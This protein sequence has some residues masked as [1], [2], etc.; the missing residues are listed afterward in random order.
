[1]NAARPIVRMRAGNTAT[2]GRTLAVVAIFALVG[3]PIGAVVIWIVFAIIDPQVWRA[4]LTLSPLELLQ[5]F[6]GTVLVAY[7]LGAA[8]SA[9]AGLVVML[10]RRANGRTSLQAPVVAA[11][12]ADAVGTIF[13]VGF[14]A[15]HFSMTGYLFSFVPPSLVAAIVC[16]LIA[17][18]VELI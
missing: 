13:F 6:F 15:G 4:I 9:L 10:L 16:W 14:G 12:V 17:R 8:L 2:L 11:L 7:K 5:F 18:K 1:M 3:P